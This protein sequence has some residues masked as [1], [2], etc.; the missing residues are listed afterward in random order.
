MLPMDLPLTNSKPVA[1]MNLPVLVL[2]SMLPKPLAT[3]V[4]TLKRFTFLTFN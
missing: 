1:P 2:G 4:A 3:P